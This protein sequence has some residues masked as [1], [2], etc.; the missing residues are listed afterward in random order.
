MGSKGTG[1]C[2][3]LLVLSTV[4][5][6]LMAGL[7]LAFDVSV[8]PGPAKTADRTYV[9]SMRSFGTVVDGSPLFE[10]VFLVALLAAF[11]AVFVEAWAGRRDARCGPRWPRRRT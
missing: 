6:G 9:T 10:T 4:L 1:L 7:F 11:A 2:T 5:V 3:F 8:M